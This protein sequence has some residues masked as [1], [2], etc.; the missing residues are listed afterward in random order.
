MIIKSEHTFNKIHSWSHEI[1]EAIESFHSKYRVYPNLFSANLNTHSK[2]DLAAN[3][4]PGNIVNN[5]TN[6]R[7]DGTKFTRISAFSFEEG[8]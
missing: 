8:V 1:I 5:M 4:K 7:S 3:S 2:I 6:E